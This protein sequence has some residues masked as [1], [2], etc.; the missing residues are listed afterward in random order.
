MEFIKFK[1]CIGYLI[2]MHN[3]SSSAYKEGVDLLEYTDPYDKCL[4]LMWGE[5]LTEY[6]EDWLSWYLYEKDGISGN[7]RED[8]KA[9]DKDEN[10]I[11][12]N[13]ENLHAYLLENNYFKN[14]KKKKNGDR[15]KSKKK[16]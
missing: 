13:L 15:S 12:E 2:Q 11:C 7:P 8:I 10:E 9:W 6:G 3:R 4:N 14:Y 5:I 1:E 16:S